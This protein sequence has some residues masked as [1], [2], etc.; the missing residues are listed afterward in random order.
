MWVR[1]RRLIPEYFIYK[2][3]MIEREKDLYIKDAHI[4]HPWCVSR[5]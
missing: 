1:Q 3:G 2:R 5:A 4:A